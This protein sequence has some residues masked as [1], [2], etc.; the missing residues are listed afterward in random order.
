M[1]RDNYVLVM[2]WMVTELGLKGNELIIY[3]I[4]YGFSQVEGQHFKGSLKYIMKWTNLT[5]QSVI[6][7]LNSLQDKGYIKK[8]V[9]YVKGIKFCE[10]S[11]ER[12]PRENQSQEIVDL[13]ALMNALDN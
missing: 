12:V 4:I 8:H 6:N 5:K 1:N 3:A 9:K 10:Y 11:C 13:D 7:C 2:G